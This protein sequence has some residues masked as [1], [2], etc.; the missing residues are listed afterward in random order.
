MSTNSPSLV[1]S[2]PTRASSSAGPQ[3]RLPMPPGSWPRPVP[4]GVR[5]AGATSPTTP[6]TS[7]SK[8]ADQVRG[9]IL[10][11][12]CICCAGSATVL[13][14][15]VEL[16]VIALAGNQNVPAYELSVES[17][18]TNC[19]G[20]EPRPSMCSRSRI[21]KFAWLDDDQA[22]RALIRASA[23]LARS[24]A[25]RGYTCARSPGGRWTAPPNVTQETIPATWRDPEDFVPL[26][27]ARP[28]TL[29]EIAH[30][31]GSRFGCR[32]MSRFP[33]RA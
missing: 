26:A 16:S 31:A 28:V 33:V 22:D 3:R 21:G 18:A 27:W 1:R 8:N 19:R 5:P 6:R 32:A 20:A 23:T 12:T 17:S 25:E 9:T 11:G 15:A 14:T 10:G 13:A 30:L 24:T 7:S 29:P 4:A 2:T